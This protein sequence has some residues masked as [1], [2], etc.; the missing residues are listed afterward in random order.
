MS[1]GIE[2][3]AVTSAVGS[4]TQVHLRYADR[5]DGVVTTTDPEVI[6]LSGTLSIH[7]MHLHLSVADRYGRQ[8]GGHLLDGCPGRTTLELTI[9]E[10]LWVRMVRV[11]DGTTGYEELEPQAN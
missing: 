3:A 10:I 4:L 9:Q 1:F 11:K 7:G 8:L 6:S 5:A 2:A